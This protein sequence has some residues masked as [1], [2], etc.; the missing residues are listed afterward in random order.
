MSRK[1][2]DRVNL[3]SDIIARY[4]EQ[5]LDERY[6]E[7][8]SEPGEGL[9]LGTDPRRRPA[10]ARRPALAGASQAHAWSRPK[11]QRRDSVMA[12]VE[13]AIEE[14]RAG[15]FVIIIDDEDRENE[16]DL[17]IAAEF[18]TP[19]HINFMATLRPRPDLHADDRRARRRSWAS[20]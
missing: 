4:V 7:G 5:L 12:T 15:R 3:E 10:Q 9:S 2:G 8:V 18:V 19:E 6:L 17:T 11:K 13:E 14:Y 1:P 20:R 16:G